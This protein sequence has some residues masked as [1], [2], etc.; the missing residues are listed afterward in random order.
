MATEEPQS[1]RRSKKQGLLVWVAWLLL[2]MLALLVL[3]AGLWAAFDKVASGLG[4][5]LLQKQGLDVYRLD[6][7]NWI[8]ALILLVAVVVV[9][10]VGGWVRVRSWMQLR[11]FIKRN[12]KNDSPD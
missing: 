12:E 8:S 5:D 10:A 1:D 7:F 9:F 11:N 3:G 4:T 2:G 6:D